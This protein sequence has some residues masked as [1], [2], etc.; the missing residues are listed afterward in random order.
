[1]PRPCRQLLS[2]EI[3]LIPA[4]FI[5]I[6]V[7]QDKHITVPSGDPRGILIAGSAL[8]EKPRSRVIR[9][10]IHTRAVG[11]VPPAYSVV[12]SDSNVALAIVVPACGILAVPIGIVP[13]MV[14]MSLVRIT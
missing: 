7:S 8:C 1:M 13:S 14:M 11:S 2:P 10:Y 4:D 5:A 12:S 9:G 6:G 3:D